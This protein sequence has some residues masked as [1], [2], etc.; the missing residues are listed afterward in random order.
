MK[1]IL[2]VEDD[3]STQKYY[4]ELFSAEGYEVTLA[5]D[6]TGG[7]MQFRAVRP[8]LVILDAEMPGG[9]GER[10]FEM[11]REI[12]ESGVPVLFVTGMPGRVEKF[13]ETYANVG[14]LAK[15]ADSDVLLARAAEMIG[16]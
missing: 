6:A 2:A 5:G 11:I 14:V 8:D 15:P 4:R 13:T 1:K 3:L 7:V 10:V 16:G 9:G 12:M